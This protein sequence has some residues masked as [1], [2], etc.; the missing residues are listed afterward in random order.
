MNPFVEQLDAMLDRMIT[1]KKQLLLGVCIV[2]AGIVGIIGYS[3]YK[4][5][6]NVSAHKAFV[7]ALKYYDGMVRQGQPSHVDSEGAFFANEQEKWEAT[8]RVFKDGYAQHKHAALAPM[9]S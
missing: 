6:T 2:G 9:L 5:W 7:A 1:Y 3:Y 4:T 8:A